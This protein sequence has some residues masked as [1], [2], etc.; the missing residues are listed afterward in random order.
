MA[1]ATKE[2]HL[3]FGHA[4]FV[5]TGTEFMA[6]D[7]AQEW[8]MKPFNDPEPPVF[9]PPMILRHDQLPPRYTNGT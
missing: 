9:P 8:S 7:L 2:G 1:F 4:N 6:P 3:V 5:L